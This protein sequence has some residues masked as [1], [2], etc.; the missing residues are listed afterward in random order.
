MAFAT[1]Y[2]GILIAGLVVGGCLGLTYASSIFYGLDRGAARGSS[3]GLHEAVLGAGASLVPFI[4]GH[5]A[6]LV[7]FER[8]AYVF[9]PGAI[10]VALAAEV[11][12]LARVRPEE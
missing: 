8:A 4:G 1:S 5:I 7:G 9:A 3:S 12:I 11:I 2:G 6:D 10:A